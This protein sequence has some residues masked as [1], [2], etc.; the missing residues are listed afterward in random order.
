MSKLI[1]KT[2][3][4]FGNH[5]F[6]IFNAISLSLDY[7]IQLIID[8]ISKDKTRPSFTKY[9]IFSHSRLIQH[10]I[11]PNIFRKTQL[12][13]QKGF[14]YQKI[15]LKPNI[16]YLID[17]SKSGF[18]QSYKFFW[19]NKD[20]IKEYINLPNERFN[21]MKEQIDQIGKKTIGIH[22]RLTDYT[23]NPKY[24]YNYPVSYYENV[25]AKFNLSDYQIILFSDDPVK[26][27][28]MLG[29]ISQYNI[30][31][32]DTISLDD[33]DQ[34]YLLMLTNVRIIPNSTYSL[35][36]CY[37]NEMYQFIPDAE[38]WIGN[39]WFGIAGPRHKLDDLVPID[40]PKFKIYNI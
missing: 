12:I 3:C 24:F 38:Y 34:F 30:I 21:K 2:I 17:A 19:H 23:K 35:W 33:E 36:T 16:D 32:A 20:K 14:L 15:I 39:K 10:Q 29:C 22:I 4:G 27:T 40:N 26:A 7:N 9:V 6:Y 11:E 13:N 5:L 37:L 25:L 28:Q 18:F 31:Q 8:T 1:L